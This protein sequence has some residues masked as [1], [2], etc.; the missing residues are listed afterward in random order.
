MLGGLELYLGIDHP[1]ASAYPPSR[2]IYFVLLCSSVTLCLAQQL[3]DRHTA[4]RHMKLFVQ[5]HWLLLPFSGFEL[6]ATC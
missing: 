2:L 6:E 5:H 3:L 4:A 1:P